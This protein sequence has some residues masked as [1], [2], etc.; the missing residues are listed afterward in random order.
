MCLKYTYAY[1]IL[2][3]F[4]AWYF[5]TLN[6]PQELSI[7]QNEIGIKITHIVL[8]LWTLSCYVLV[9]LI[10]HWII[11]MN[12]NFVYI[13][14]YLIPYIWCYSFWYFMEPIDTFL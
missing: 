9:I 3:V 6:D 4:G 7:K 12:A 10:C 2:K 5:G 13:K 11:V 1:E 8:V 14:V